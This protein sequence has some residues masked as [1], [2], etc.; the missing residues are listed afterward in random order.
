MSLGIRTKLSPAL[1]R[2]TVRRAFQ[3]F[4]AKYDLVYFGQVDQ[5]TD[6]HQLVRGVTATAWHRDRHYSVGHINGYDVTIL[7]RDDRLSFPGKPTHDYHWAI[8]Q[9]DLRASLP[10][11]FIDANHYDET[12]YAH[13]LVRLSRLQNFNHMFENASYADF[14]KA[15]KVYG[16]PELATHLYQLITPEI[17]TMLKA[18]FS[19][20]DYEIADDKL[21][22]YAQTRLITEHLLE[23]MLRVGL[24][25]AEQLED[26]KTASVI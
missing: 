6:E 8:M 26:T 16:Q 7:R 13:L 18:H 25:L 10:H 17:A 12:F 20:F 22:I 9:L 24:W 5:R 23:H 2:H 19:Q 1:A 14:A 15:F 4:A 21:I 3:R 11:V